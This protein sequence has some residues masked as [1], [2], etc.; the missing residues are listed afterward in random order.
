[1]SL[2]ITY[3]VSLINHNVPSEE[4]LYERDG[5]D[6]NNKNIVSSPGN[7]HLSVPVPWP[8]GVAAECGGWPSALPGRLARQHGGQRAAHREG[9]AQRAARRARDQHPAR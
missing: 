6:K 7:V 4:L 2:I 8:Q 5:I 3:H 9:P 1:M